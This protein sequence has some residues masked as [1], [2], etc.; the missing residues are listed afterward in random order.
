[1]SRREWSLVFGVAAVIVVAF[2]SILYGFSVFVTDSA[3]G[4]EFST[5]VLSLGLTGAGIVGGLLAVPLG[6]LM[7]RRG[8][9]GVLLAGALLGGL[10]MAAFAAAQEPWHVVAAWWLLLG[11]AGALLYYEPAFVAIGIWVPLRHQPRAFGVLTL[12]G[13][14]AGGVFIPLIQWMVNSYGWRPTAATLGALIF[15][16]ASVVAVT[17]IPAGV[18]PHRPSAEPTP[19]PRLR[20]LYGDRRFTLFTAALVL[21]FLPIQGILAHRV[22]R[23]SE[24]GFAATTVALWAGA[25]SFISMPGRYLAP[26]MAP[27][28]GSARL[29]AAVIAAIA[30]STALAVP[31]DTSLSLVG[32]FVVFGVAFGALTPL[33]ASVMTEWYGGEH[34]GAIMGAQWST[35]TLVGASGALI[36]GAARDLLGSYRIPLSVAAVMLAIAAALT[37]AA[38]RANRTPPV[39]V[40]R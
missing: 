5:S 22:D 4:A 13:G 19:R 6:R 20:A 1:M 29:T 15:V 33:R 39:G 26:V 24:V 3:A 27:R 10:G 11:P 14:L 31:G 37:V 23:F 16:V 2:G 34:Y 25:A 7:D 35:V 12:L 9:R 17:V 28:I 36:M 30:I 21:T 8:V 40:F 18:Q 32:H 38:G